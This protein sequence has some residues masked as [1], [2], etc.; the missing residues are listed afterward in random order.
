MSS[1][2]VGHRERLKESFD[3]NGGESLNDINFLELLL[4]YA[5]PRRDT[6][7]LAHALL[8]R[9]GSLS[10]VLDASE[11]E[12]ASVSGLGKSSARLLKIARD[13]VRRYTT[14]PLRDMKVM[15]KRSQLGAYFVPLLQYETEEKVYLMCLNAK[16][17]VI[18]CTLLNSGTVSTVSVKIRTAVDIAMR[19][20][21][22]GVVLAHNHPGGNAIPSVEDRNFTRE[23]K[24]ALELM[25]IRLYDHIIVAGDQYVSFVQSAYM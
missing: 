14:E 6:N 2:H 22:M 4:F 1:I 15:T 20:K 12:L 9:F 13:V 11:Q 18:S 8:N 17:G 7:E 19:Q 5:I 23:L 10:G 25:D 21:A 16:G 3:K 24:R